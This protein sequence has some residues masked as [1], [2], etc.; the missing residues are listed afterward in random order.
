[1]FFRKKEVVKKHVEVK[2]PEVYVIPQIPEESIRLR[3]LKQQFERTMAV[4][5]MEGPY[6]KDVLSVPDVGVKQ[7]IDLAYDPFRVEKKL[8]EED[9]IER[10][11]EKYHEFPSVDSQ[12]DPANY[13]KKPSSTE[14]KSSGVGINFGGI[15]E[16]VSTPEVEVKP[17]IVFPKIEEPVKRDVGF[18]P[19]NVSNE[20]KVEQEEYI[21]RPIVRPIEHM[22]VNNTAVDESIPKTIVM[23]KINTPKVEEVPTINIPPFMTQPSSTT[24]EVE[25][26]IILDSPAATVETKSV[27]DTYRVFD[28]F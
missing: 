16:P 8:T 17:N 22:Q 18:E 7:D 25:S 10:F 20:I 3:E 26:E 14:Q 15:I 28:D 1:M 19:I 13:E 11:G 4:S 5:P 24:T 6:T 9:E 2:E 27:Y 23:G 12:V 21:A